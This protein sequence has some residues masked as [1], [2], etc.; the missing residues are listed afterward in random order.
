[1]GIYDR[2]FDFGASLDDI[3]HAAREF[4]EKMKEM[5]PDMAP[6]FEGCYGPFDHG[7]GARP[8]H[9]HP[10]VYFYPPTNAYAARDGSL[11]FEFAMAGMD[12][13]AVKIE[14][15]GDYLVL[16]A[17]A[18]RRGAG[19]GGSGFYR[20]GFRPRGIYRQK[21]SV[22]AADYAQDQAK[23]VFRNGV[24]TVTIPPKE[25]EGEAIRIEIIKEG[26]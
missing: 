21:Y 14:F 13:S 24:L 5:G 8:R 1:M 25:P 4:G 16:S 3:V 19:A 11:V 10:K 26:D 7:S 22:P 17:K 23:A 12:E 15:Q 6:W 2:N 9:E 20:P 18:G